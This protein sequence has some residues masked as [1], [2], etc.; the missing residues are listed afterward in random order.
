MSGSILHIIPSKELTFMSSCGLPGAK[1]QVALTAAKW[2]RFAAVDTGWA[3]GT[4]MPLAR[5]WSW[6]FMHELVVTIPF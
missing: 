1:D 6:L 2:V 3:L 5:L 4:M